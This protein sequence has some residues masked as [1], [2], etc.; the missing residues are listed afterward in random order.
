VTHKDGERSI[1]RGSCLCHLLMPAQLMLGNSGVNA[2]ESRLP[3]VALRCLA[4]QA[5]VSLGSGSRIS[6]K[7]RDFSALPLSTAREIERAAI[8][9]GHE[10][11]I[12]QQVG[13]FFGP[14]LAE[15]SLPGPPTVS[16]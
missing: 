7:A 12:R 9:P 14:G 8:V 11:R 13:Y 2:R 6:I 15:E 1:C 3:L 4:M 10:Q 16:P 5:S